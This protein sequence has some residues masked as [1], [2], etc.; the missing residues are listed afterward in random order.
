MLKWFYLNFFFT[1]SVVRLLNIFTCV[2]FFFL[3]GVYV[4]GAKIVEEDVSLKNGVLHI[5]NKL[6]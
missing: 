4:N 6:L 2:D 3:T 1:I 5:I